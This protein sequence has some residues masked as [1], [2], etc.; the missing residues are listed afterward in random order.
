MRCAPATKVRDGKRDAAQPR[1]E[2]VAAAERGETLQRCQEDVLGQVV[3]VLQVMN[4]AGEVTAQ[5]QRVP[6]HEL[7]EF[8]QRH[9]RHF[10]MLASRSGVRLACWGWQCWLGYWSALAAS[11][12]TRS[13]SREPHHEHET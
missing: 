2:V 4:L 3:H 5:R 9:P 11:P 10:V 13:A 1:P 8:R 12:A 6:A 7:P